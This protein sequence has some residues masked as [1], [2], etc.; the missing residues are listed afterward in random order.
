MGLHSVEELVRKPR[1]DED[2]MR[3]SESEERGLAFV[4]LGLN[5]QLVRQQVA[6]WN[7]ENRSL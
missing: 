3:V 7:S 2:V 1:H 6:L 4:S 5:Q